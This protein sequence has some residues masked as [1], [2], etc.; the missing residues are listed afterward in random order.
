MGGAAVFRVGPAD[1]NINVIIETLTEHGRRLA[2][3]QRYIPEIQQ[4]DKR[5]LLVDGEPVPYCPGPHPSR[6]RDP[7]QPRRGCHR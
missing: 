2:M 5:I 7:G 4:G 1:P 6:G 3:A